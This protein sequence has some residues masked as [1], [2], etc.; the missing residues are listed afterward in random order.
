MLA[1]LI[2][3]VHARIIFMT[4]ETSLLSACLIWIEQFIWS[5]FMRHKGSAVDLRG[6]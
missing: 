6:F 3:S 1:S 2:A 5:H 4:S